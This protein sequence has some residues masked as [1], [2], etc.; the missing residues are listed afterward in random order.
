MAQPTQLEIDSIIA[1][2]NA[3]DNPDAFMES[4]GWPVG[5]TPTDA[6]GDVGA[7][8]EHVDPQ[9]PFG[10]DNRVITPSQQWSADEAA[11]GWYGHVS[12]TGLAVFSQLVALGFPGLANDGCA[13]LVNQNCKD[14]AE[15]LAVWAADVGRSNPEHRNMM[16]SADVLGNFVGTTG[17]FGITGG[18]YTLTLIAE[19]YY[20]VMGH[21]PA[22]SL[23]WAVGLD[24]TTYNVCVAWDVGYY[25]LWLPAQG[26]YLV[27][28]G[29]E[30]RVVSVNTNKIQE[31]TGTNNRL[32]LGDLPWLTWLYGAF[33]G[34]AADPAGRNDWRV[35][36]ANGWDREHVM[37]GFLTSRE[38][39][40]AHLADY[41]GA[42]F[43]TVLHRAIQPG[44]R[45]AFD[46]NM[47]RTAV[48]V[49]TSPEAGALGL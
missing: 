27:C 41:V 43:L 6:A 25:S 7:I 42:V 17:A 20:H 45:G 9:P 19:P 37:I 13:Q 18:M 34:R 35:N 46:T 5:S 10:L 36:L 48:N 1:L 30:R 28:N 38:Y 23:V 21:A 31:L 47:Y 12:P 26:N 44:E 32:P 24:D 39:I 3:R 8:V 2:N 49:V 22:G 33:L 11:N 15:C 4:I 29:L 14:P 40:N 16:L